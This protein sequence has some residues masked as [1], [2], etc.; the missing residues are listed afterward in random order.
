M[1]A[2]QLNRRH[3]LI[4]FLTLIAAGASLVMS[5]SLARAV[6]IALL[7][8]ALA[9]MLGLNSRVVHWLF[10]GT[11]LVI[12]VGTSALDGYLHPYITSL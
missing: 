12:V 9:W 4:L 1:M 2:I 11:G 7:G 3:K 10:L 5:A 6:G 8:A